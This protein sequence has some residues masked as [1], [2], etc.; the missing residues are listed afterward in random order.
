MK[1]GRFGVNYSQSETTVYLADVLMREALKDW[2]SKI[3]FNSHINII[4]KIGRIRLT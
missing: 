1:T 3:R 4:T 2:A